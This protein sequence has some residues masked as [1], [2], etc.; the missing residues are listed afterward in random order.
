MS[1]VE[2]NEADYVISYL[3]I[4]YILACKYKCAYLKVKL[5]KKHYQLTN[6]INKYV[7]ICVN[8]RAHSV[9]L[10]IK[11]AGI[12]KERKKVHARI[13]LYFNNFMNI[14]FSRDMYLI[15]LG[16]QLSAR[17]QCAYVNLFPYYIRVSYRVIC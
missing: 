4:N 13:Q 6:N 17:V 5:K 8:I 12:K 2:F 9:K 14:F 16:I 7:P 11:L 10:K 15:Y 1:A 3:L